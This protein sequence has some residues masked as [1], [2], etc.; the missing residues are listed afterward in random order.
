MRAFAIRAG[1]RY[2]FYHFADVGKMKGQGC[3]VGNVFGTDG[4]SCGQVV[5]RG[6][7]LPAARAGCFPGNIEQQPPR[8]QGNGFI[9]LYSALYAKIGGKCLAKGGYWPKSEQWAKS[10]IEPSRAGNF[11]RSG[12]LDARTPPW[13]GRGIC[14]RWQVM[15]FFQIFP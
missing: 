15:N 3:C 12:R 9:S 11:L 4:A 5:A 6:A 8:M 2:G 7:T 1:A 10:A 13:A 14:R